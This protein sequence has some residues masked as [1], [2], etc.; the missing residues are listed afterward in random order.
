LFLAFL[1]VAGGLAAEPL[2]EFSE[3]AAEAA[4]NQE[5][6][7]AVVLEGDAP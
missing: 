6:Y 4:T 1:L 3:L 2:V 7:R 5:A